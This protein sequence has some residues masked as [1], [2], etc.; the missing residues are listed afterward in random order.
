MTGDMERFSKLWGGGFSKSAFRLEQLPVYSVTAEDEGWKDFSSGVLL[1]RD[2]AQSELVT[3]LRSMLHDGQRTMSRIHVIEDINPYIQFE[4]DWGYRYNAS[5]GEQIFLMHG[6][7]FRRLINEKLPD[8]WV[9][10]DEIVAEMSYD[11]AGQ[12]TGVT[13]VQEPKQVH[14]YISIRDRLLPMAISLKD[15]YAALR[16][17]TFPWPTTLLERISK[18]T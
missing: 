7:A 17:E 1:P 8:Y 4:M 18:N 9:F 11:D 5:A 12:F 14:K 3:K 10:D 15:F 6:P 2:K 13:F 16:R